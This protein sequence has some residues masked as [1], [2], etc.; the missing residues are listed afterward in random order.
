MKLNMGQLDRSL[1]IGAAVLV[2]IL[3]W[4]GV[5]KGTWATVLLILAAIFLITSIIGFCPVYRLLGINTCR[6]KT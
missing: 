6:K 1:R 2:G 3:A 5:L 4:T